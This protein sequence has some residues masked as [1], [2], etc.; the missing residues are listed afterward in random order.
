MISVNKIVKKINN[1]NKM[2]IKA[3]TNE[4]LSNKKK[5]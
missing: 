5:V 1:G 3:K 2:I 4:G